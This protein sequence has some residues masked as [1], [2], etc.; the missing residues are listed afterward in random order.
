MIDHKPRGC[1]KESRSKKKRIFPKTFGVI[2]NIADVKQ[3]FSECKE[4]AEKEG[5]EVF[6]IQVNSK[7]VQ[8]KRCIGSNAKILELLSTCFQSL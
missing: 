4:L 5:Y 1:Y 6:A 8:Q 3:V 2:K 7:I